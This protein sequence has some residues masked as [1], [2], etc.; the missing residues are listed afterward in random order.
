MNHINNERLNS[1]TLYCECYSSLYRR[2]APQGFKLDSS[3]MY[4]LKI[5]VETETRYG[6]AVEPMKKVFERR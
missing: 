4:N 3:T 6:D 5:L 2:I 1:S